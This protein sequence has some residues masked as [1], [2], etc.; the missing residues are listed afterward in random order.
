MIAGWN[1]DG[2]GRFAGLDIDSVCSLPR[3]VPGSFSLAVESR[4]LGLVGCV[5]S[6]FFAGEAK[7][8]GTGDDFNG[9][10]CGDFE[11][12]LGSKTSSS[13]SSELPDDPVL[14]ICVAFFGDNGSFFLACLSSPAS[15]DFCFAA[16]PL[17]TGLAV[18]P[19]PTFPLLLVASSKGW[20]SL[21]ECSV[22]SRNVTFFLGTHDLALLMSIERSAAAEDSVDDR[23]DAFVALVVA[24]AFALRAEVVVI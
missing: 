21:S 3:G 9:D 2:G 22:I 16:V 19:V 1:G 11:G 8:G 17:R 10:L 7:E 24:G 23:V 13:S 5:K 4:E 14:V 12:A 20:F 15:D 18:M 6:I